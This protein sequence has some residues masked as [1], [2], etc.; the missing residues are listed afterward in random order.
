MKILITGGHVTPAVAIIE[1]LK[2]NPTIQAVFVGGKYGEVKG[3]ALSYEYQSI[4]HLGVRFIH[5]ETGRLTRLF[6][7]FTILDFVSFP[8]GLFRSFCILQKEKPDVILSFGGYIAFPIAISA[9]FLRIRIF[10]HEQTL[11]PGITNRL[12]ACFAQKIFISFPE[13]KRFFDKR[14]TITTGN[15]L[16][17]SIFHLIKKPF[18]IVKTRPIIYITGGSLG[19]HSINRIIEGILPDLLKKYIVIHQTG[20]IAKY[21]DFERLSMYKDKNYFLSRHFASDEIGS[22]YSVSDVIIARSGANTICELIALQKPALLI[23]RGLREVNKKLMHY[24]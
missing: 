18:S 10:T 1:E 24:F 23:F 15:P 6:S 12:I 19:S 20:N 17:T 7:L 22:I 11:V 9:F 8:L 2:K 5:L 13:T 4:I 3:K 21:G 14:K 16:R